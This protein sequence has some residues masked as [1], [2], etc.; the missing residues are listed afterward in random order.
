MG[1]Q[2]LI[3]TTTVSGHI[4]SSGKFFKKGAS[5][6]YTL[7]FNDGAYVGR[8]TIKCGTSAAPVTALANV[9]T[10]TL[11]SSNFARDVLPLAGIVALVAP[12]AMAVARVALNRRRTYE[13]VSIEVV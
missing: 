4:G 5:S 9:D 12:A 2:G 10:S 3:D 7:G 8:V 6:P 1:T 11:A 13:P